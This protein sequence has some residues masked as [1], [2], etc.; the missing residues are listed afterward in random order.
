MPVARTL[1]KAAKRWLRPLLLPFARFAV[2]YAPGG[3]RRVAWQ[4]VVEPFFQHAAHDFIATTRFGA[5]VA[6]NTVDLI[7]RYIFY[8]GEWEPNLT[9]YLADR[10]RAGDVFVDVGANIGYFTLLASLLVGPTGK[11]VAIEASPTIHDLLLDN[12]RRNRAGNVEAINVAASDREGTAKVFL[13]PDSNIGKTSIVET[14]E[15]RYECEV[16]ARPIDALIGPDLLARVRLVKIDVEGTEWLV[17]GGMREALRRA[18]PDLE[19]VVELSPSVLRAQGTT[20]EEVMA[21]FAAARF[22]PYR[23]ENDYSVR[24]YVSPASARPRRITTPI[25]AQTDVI[26]SRRDAEFL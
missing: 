16:P 13:F 12:L 17:I 11:V 8:F 1:K 4:Y 10:L 26:F 23:L 5:I 6:G 14:D 7:Q 24:S 3:G 15:G 21:V 18:H 9:R 19:V 22:F 25:V 2:R 20:V